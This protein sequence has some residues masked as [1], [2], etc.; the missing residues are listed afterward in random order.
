L[1][2]TIKCIQ[3]TPG[4]ILHSRVKKTPVYYNPFNFLYSTVT[5]ISTRSDSFQ[6]FVREWKRALGKQ[7]L[8]TCS[9]QLC[10]KKFSLVC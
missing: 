7:S 5:T 6:A 9:G 1:L 10:E 4:Q 8:I 2:C 3:R